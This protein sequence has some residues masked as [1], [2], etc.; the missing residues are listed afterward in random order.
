MRADFGSEHRLQ[1]RRLAV[2]HRDVASELAGRR[3]DLR[4]D[5]A[6][7]HDDDVLGARQRVAQPVRVVDRAQQMDPG[8]PGTRDVEP[9]RRG[10]G[11]EEQAGVREPIAGRGGTTWSARSML[12][13]AASV[14]IST[15]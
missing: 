5:P 10:A 8:E 11:R 9:A 7:S 13:T 12:T 2:D 1:R 14:R 6:A 3:R 4:A 15:S